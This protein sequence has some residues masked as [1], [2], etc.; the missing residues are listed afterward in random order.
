MGSV[1]GGLL[2]LWLGRI[3]RGASRVYVNS[4]L[5]ARDEERKAYLFS[6]DF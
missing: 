4:L 6:T 3:C 1:L 5:Q 2:D